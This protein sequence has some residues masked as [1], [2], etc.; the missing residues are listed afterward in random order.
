MKDSSEQPVGTFSIDENGL[1]TFE[2]SKEFS[3]D[4]FFECKVGS[5]K[6]QEEVTFS[7]PGKGEVTYTIK[8]SSLAFDIETKKEAGGVVQDVD[9]EWYVTYTMTISSKKGTGEDIEVFDYF[10]DNIVGSQTKQVIRLNSISIKDNNDNNVENIQVIQYKDSGFKTT[11]PKLEAGQK[12]TITCV[13]LVNKQLLS[14]SA[15][16]KL[17]LNKNIFYAR[18]GKK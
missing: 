17:K 18:S 16:T 2:Y 7:F 5:R 8:P 4:F 13:A 11:L 9:G 15:T 6:T 1:V 12:Y 14:T 10:D 3:G